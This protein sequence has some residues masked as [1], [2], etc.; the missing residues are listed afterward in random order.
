MVIRVRSGFSSSFTRSAEKSG[1]APAGNPSSSSARVKAAAS[2]GQ[3]GE[4][5]Q[6]ADLPSARATDARA[7]GALEDPGGEEDVAGAGGRPVRVAHA[8]Q[9]Q[10]VVVPK[11]SVLGGDEMDSGSGRIAIDRVPPE[12][13]ANP[14]AETRRS[15]H[16]SLRQRGIRCLGQGI[17][18]GA[19]GRSREVDADEG[20]EAANRVAE[21]GARSADR[22]Q[23]VGVNGEA[24][25]NFRRED[26]LAAA[27]LLAGGAGLLRDLPGLRDSGLAQPA[28]PGRQ[29]RQSLRLVR[30]RDV[31]VRQGVLGYLGRTPRGAG[32]VRVVEEG[33]A[34][35]REAVGEAAGIFREGESVVEARGPGLFG[36]RGPDPRL[37]RDARFRG[38]GGEGVQVG[39]P[40][41][42]RR[43]RSG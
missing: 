9:D 28:H 33:T 29:L 3:A 19:V 35:E 6:K 2:P 10:A 21:G 36:E 7:G 20:D 1:D 30:V 41:Y 27:S 17:E 5:S 24:P 13:A 32:K 8:E 38:P 12:L 4:G 34:E 22:R 15:T 11:R 42:G 18:R 14:V 23:G 37:K 40:G 31:R 25:Q 39:G 16:R 26:Q 43:S